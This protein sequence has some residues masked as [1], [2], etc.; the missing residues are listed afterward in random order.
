[1][2]RTSFLF[3][4]EAWQVRGLR[5]AEAFFRA[6]P[7]LLPGATHLCL[8]GAPAPEI[9]ALIAGHV[10]ATAAYPAPA[11]T[12]WSWPRDRRCLL[13]ASPVLFGA[14]A[15]ASGRHAAPEICSHLHL[16]RGADPLAQWFDAFDDP[17][18]V[19]KEVPRDRIERFCA[20]TGGECVEG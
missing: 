8:E 5:D 4:R 3:D 9:A 10:D 2:M 14:L 16:Y 1:M 20:A 12:I 17:L 7:A 18:Y 19:S 6:V 11:G 15:A 13:R